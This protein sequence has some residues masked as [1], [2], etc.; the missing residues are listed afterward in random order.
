M[1]ISDSGHIANFLRDIS[2][3]MYLQLQRSILNNNVSDSP[4]DSILQI[5]VRVDI[6]NFIKYSNGEI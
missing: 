4:S 2:Y 5:M 6:S 3:Q 1:N